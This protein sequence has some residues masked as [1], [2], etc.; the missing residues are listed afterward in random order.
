VWL[1]YCLSRF[2]FIALSIYFGAGLSM[3][4]ESASPAT[5]QKILDRLDVLEKENQTLLQ[6][7]KSLR[8]EVK[9]QPPPVPDQ[10]ADDLKDRVGVAENRIQEQAQTKVG[11][12][13]RFPVSLNG[14]ILFDS[15]L[16][17]GTENPN[18]QQAFGN[19]GEGAPGGGATLRQSIIGLTV[20]GPHI[21]GG[22]Q[23]HGSL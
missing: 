3:A 18:F 20:Q 19:Y 15:S 1:S 11:S 16:I 17:H 4:Q 10:A 13:Q 21:A 2:A 5:M 8:E 22:G 9:A 7:I 14:M 12:S 6:E 23:I